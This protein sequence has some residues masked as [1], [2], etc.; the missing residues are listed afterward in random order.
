M[1]LALASSSQSRSAIDRPCTLARTWPRVNASMETSVPTSGVNPG[2]GP[3][4]QE[5][6]AAAADGA[7]VDMARPPAASAEKLAAKATLDFK[8]ARRCGKHS[9]GHMMKPPVRLRFDELRMPE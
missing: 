1:V 3:M 2:C 6:S 5:R 7:N 8:M 9:S 4:T